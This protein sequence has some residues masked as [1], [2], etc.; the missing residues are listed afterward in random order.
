M[1]CGGASVDDQI[2]STVEANLRRSTVESGVAATLRAL[3]SPTPD[4]ISDS[5]NA[6]LT[7]QAFS[8]TVAASVDKTRQAQEGATRTAV[9]TLVA[10]NKFTLDQSS[11]EPSHTSSVAVADAIWKAQTFVPSVSGY[12]VRVELSGK[13][14]TGTPIL[15]VRAA[16]QIVPADTDLGSAEILADSV[17]DFGTGIPLQAGKTYA[18][19]VSDRQGTF[20]WEYSNS[21]SCYPNVRGV[22]FTS[23]DNGVTWSRDIVDFHFATYMAP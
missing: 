12:L 15:H 23:L 16:D 14:Q 20:Y 2:H 11:C 6:T 8:A 7:A 4:L 9:Q 10:D 1:G 21:P 3:V 19:V 5:V 18:L 17:A 13:T 22:P